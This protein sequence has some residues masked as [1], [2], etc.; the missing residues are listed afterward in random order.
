MQ[1]AIKALRVLRALCAQ[2]VRRASGGPHLQIKEARCTSPRQESA[3]CKA[4]LDAQRKGCYSSSE[5]ADRQAARDLVR[6]RPASSRWL[7]KRSS[8][9]S[10]TR[11]TLSG[12]RG[13]AG[14]SAANRKVHQVMQRHLQVM[15]HVSETRSASLAAPQARALHTSIHSASSVVRWDTPAADRDGAKSSQSAPAPTFGGFRSQYRSGRLRAHVSH[16]QMLI[17]SIRIA[18][19]GVEASTSKPSVQLLRTFPD[20]QAADATGKL[21]A[22]TQASILGEY[23]W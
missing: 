11:N 23:R 12:Q 7:R 17:C 13:N 22:R 20:V 10:T 6:N 9:G 2:R 14:G 21:H 5:G 8:M 3:Q 15:K 18:I 4:K 1:H 16:V 19:L